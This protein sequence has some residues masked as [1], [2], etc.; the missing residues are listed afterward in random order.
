[1][2]IEVTNSGGHS[3]LPP[4]ENAIHQ[5]T[6]ALDRLARFELPAALNDVTRAWFHEMSQVD[7]GPN[8]AEMKTIGSGQLDP[9]TVARLSDSVLPNALLHTTCIPPCSLRA[10][11]KTR[12]PRELRPR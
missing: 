3:S 5:L 7:P 4:K 10:M 1:L 8:A 9:Q 2:E 6:V 11:R 12:C